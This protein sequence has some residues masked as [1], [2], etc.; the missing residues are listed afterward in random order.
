MAKAVSFLTGK[1]YAHVSIAL[2]HEL[3]EVYSFARINIDSP[4]PAGFV[5]EDLEVIVGKFK[6]SICC[7]Y[8]LAV[9]GP[10]YHKIKSELNDR[11][12]INA[13]K[14]RYN[15]L[16]LPFLYIRL[17]WRRKYHYVCSQFCG[18]LLADCEIT[19]FDKDYSILLPH[20]F[21]EINNLKLIYEGKTLD[22]LANIG[23]S[24]I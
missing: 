24:G 7:I 18:K 14:Y 8:E 10:Q 16:G 23:T 11:Y 22:Y 3:K 4:F 1:K 15:Y 17:P 6:H 13:S 9:T 21:C 20:D 19:T 2:D 12:I 5:R